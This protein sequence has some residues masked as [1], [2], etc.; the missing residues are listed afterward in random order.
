MLAPK[1]RWVMKQADEQKVRT[2]SSALNVSPMTARLLINRGV[3]DP[4]HARVFL[5]PD[6]GS[7]YDPIRLKDM[8]KAA[9][10]IREAIAGGE[11]IRIFGDYDADGVTSTAIVIRALRRMGAQ[12]SSFIPNRFR[13][14]Y[15]PNAAAVEQ[16]KRDGVGLIV[17]VDSGIAASRAA[18]RARQ[19]DIDYIVTDHHEAP[20]NLPEASAVVDP[21]QPGCGYPFKGLCGAGVA[22]KLVRALSSAPPEDDLIMLAAIGTIADLV[23]LTD[24]NRWIASKGL[25]L[26]AAGAAG[27]PGIR[28]LLE[29][30]GC[31]GEVDSE[32]IGFQL[33]PRLNAAGRLADAEP[34]LRL[35]LTEETTEAASLAEEL[36]R[37]NQSRKAFVDAITRE[38]EK[39]VS[40]YARRGDRAFVLVG[41]NWHQGVVGIVASR[42][43]EHYYRP[44]IMLSIDPETGVARGSGRS[45]DGFNLYRAL[46]DSA[47]LLT[48]FGGHQMAAGLTMEASEIDA[49]RERFVHRAA[50]VL[51]GGTIVPSVFV[52]GSCAPDE[53]TVDQIL[54]FYRL[55]PFGEG[56]PEPTFLIKDAAVSRMSRVGRDR[57][58]L[59]MAFQGAGKNIDGIGFGLGETGDELT[60]ADRISA[61]GRWQIN[62][63]NGVKKPQLLIEDLSVDGLQVFDW[64]SERAIN[65]RLIQLPEADTAVVAFHGDTP[66]RLHLDVNA[67]TYA[68]GMIIRKPR[69]VLLDLPDGSGRLARL[70]EESPAVNRI[71]AV[72]DHPGEHYFSSFPTRDHF[73]TYYALI[74]RERSFRL[75][76][77]MPRITRSKGWPESLIR[78]MTKVFSELNFVKIERDLLTLNPNP[79]KCSLTDS[80]TYRN[81]K[82]QLEMEELFCYS[83]LSSLK[84]WFEQRQQ[85]KKNS[86]EPGEKV[87]GL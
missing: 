7:F 60:P 57:A 30:A 5:D 75:T 58:H 13:D 29:R 80:P 11:K 64:R 34:A 46:E 28:A 73:K 40:A 84:A 77:M 62:E 79:K 26:I 37:L 70:I 66:G 20:A 81:E 59:K 49:F 74:R 41:E 63:W 43:V 24:E 50:E 54:E 32:T 3:D 42:I 18:N 56:N 23:P 52:D 67:E 72:F 19:L 31:S 68:D 82:N 55:A 86:A 35:L 47:G 48:R 4:E 61:I 51:D 16:A 33:G 53:V 22:L 2:L 44:T 8:A 39:Q 36:E 83:S 78:F 12:V 87:N 69:L 65:D 9:K 10:R 15:G 25:R 14:G 45:I 1:A 6:K 21:K 38:A 71:Y 76:S 27:L 85:S 17:T